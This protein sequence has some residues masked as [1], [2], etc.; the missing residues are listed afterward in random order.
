MHAGKK[1]E[2]QLIID[3]LQACI[4]FDSLDAGELGSVA[5]L[6]EIQ[7]FRKGHVFLSGDTCAES[8]GLR[9]LRS[10]A[11]ELRGAEDQ[12]VER[13]GEG[14]SF[15]LKGLLSEQPDVKAVLI[16]DSLLYFLNEA[17]YQSLRERL[18]DFDRFFH[19]QC[20]RRVRRAARY[21][22]A[23]N[24]MLRQVGDLMSRDL[25]SVEPC[26]S[27]QQ[28]AQIMSER[29][30][31]SVLVLESERLCGIVTDRDIRSRAVAAGLDLQSPVSDIMT[32]GPAGI[33]ETASLFDA[34]L[35]MTERGFHHI[36]VL[37]DERALG[38][39]GAK[40]ST[41]AHR[42]SVVGIITASDLMLARQ[43]DPVFL[44][45][46]IRRETSLSGIHSVVQQLPNL[47]VQ[48]QH[49]GVR[50]Y[51]ISRILT[52]VSDAVTR[53][54][55]ELAI[56][57]LGEPPVAFCWL[58]FGSQGRGEQLLGADQDNGLLI[59]DE[60]SDADKP[61]FEAMA[62]RVCDGL[63]SCGY[64]YCN[65]GIMA[66]TNE[67]R[68][69]LA[70]WRRTVDRWTQS[71]TADAVMRV[72]IFFDL[73][74][75]YGDKKLCDQLQAHMLKRAGDNSIFLA[76]LA[77]NVLDAPPPLGIFRRFVVEH[78]GEHRDEL[79]LKKRAI[80]P[81]VD[82]ARIHCLANDIS[83]VNTLERLQALA[84]SR[85]LTIGES[86]NLQDAWS[87]IMQVRVEAQARQVVAADD[88]SHY[89][90]PDA[91]S[92]LERKL[93]RDAFKVVGDALSAIGMRYRPGLG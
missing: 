70:S 19:S 9:I 47:L 84:D 42:P 14:E 3:F 38:V 52:A 57:A 24:D 16:E 30:V 78:N 43:D 26:I 23:P 76:A 58:G 25:L 5:G 27:I 80:L 55:I 64:V 50:A 86:R 89:L 71:P 91:L 69:P 81:I 56:K 87:V 10:G 77:V 72:S 35:F 90:N 88:I 15:N 18:R 20:S 66:T 44:V 41:L 37:N 51:Q 61:W 34:I 73:R 21:D 28:T 67:W 74:S 6:L 13:L 45:Q 92:Q 39:G 85:V 8:G 75:V 17:S 62:T 65:G 63:N 48:W 82:M 40:G 22:P 33:T 7:Y 53:R 60:L 4:P 59:S 31:S 83:A 46:H 32:A 36:P 93:L 54:L 29:R 79:N 2:L 11:A 12:L 68:Q 1:L 49:V